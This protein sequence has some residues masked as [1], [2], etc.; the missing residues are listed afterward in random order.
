MNNYFSNLKRVHE[1][2]FLEMISLLWNYFQ[3]CKGNIHPKKFSI[4]DK[5]AKNTR[6]YQLS[7]ANLSLIFQ[8]YD[9]FPLLLCF[10]SIFSQIKIFPQVAQVS[11]Q[12]I[13]SFH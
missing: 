2:S 12:V 10:A 6:K 13:R 8:N 1:D 4:F 7:I 3:K 5:M 11:F 9:N